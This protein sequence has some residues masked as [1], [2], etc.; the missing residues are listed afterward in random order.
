MKRVLTVILFPWTTLLLFSQQGSFNH[1][2]ADFRQRDIPLDDTVVN[3]VQLFDPGKN[4][5]NNENRQGS[6]Q[7]VS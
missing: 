7:K 5:K 4:Q 3:H 6:V 2:I 1:F